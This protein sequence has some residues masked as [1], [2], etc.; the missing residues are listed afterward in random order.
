ME[1]A[2]IS[3]PTIRVENWTDSTV[4]AGTKNLA[5]YDTAESKYWLVG[6]GGGVVEPAISRSGSS[7]LWVQGTHSWEDGYIDVYML[8]MP[9]IFSANTVY[10][11]G[12][13][14]IKKSGVPFAASTAYGIGTYVN[15]TGDGPDCPSRT[16]KAKVTISTSV[17]AFD[18]DQWAKLG[19]PD[20]RIRYTH[21][22]LY[23][24]PIGPGPFSMAS[25]W[26][27]QTG[28]RYMDT[29]CLVRWTHGMVDAPVQG[30]YCE[31][32]AGTNILVWYDCNVLPGWQT[33]S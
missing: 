3:S 20:G 31:G 28:L 10:Y 30:H 13:Q 5:Y 16:Y 24:E 17:G 12:E 33:I 6:G 4:A 21:T 27:A 15:F 19:D 14:V 25:G 23:S 11:S 1:G 7:A 18:P 26:Q 22:G 8:N 9:A 29:G 2:L 32:G